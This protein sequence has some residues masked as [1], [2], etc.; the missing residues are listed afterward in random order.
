[1]DGLKPTFKISEP[2]A[3]ANNI[4]LIADLLT[5]AAHKYG[6]DAT[7]DAKKSVDFE[8]NSI[9]GG[10]VSKSKVCSLAANEGSG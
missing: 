7:C 8:S 6:S 4:E 2:P 9:S 3:P 10:V 5:Q 1:M